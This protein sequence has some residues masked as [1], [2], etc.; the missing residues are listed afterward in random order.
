MKAPKRKY[1]SFE[2][3]AGAGGFTLGLEEAGFHCIGAVEIDAVASQTFERNF[4]Q[5]PCS[6]LG[7][8]NGDVTRVDLR[9]VKRKIRELN[10]DLDLLVAGAPCQGFSRVGRG[11]LDSLNSASGSFAQDPR[12]RL[13]REAIRFLRGLRPRFFLFENVSGIL[14]LRGR[15]AAEDICDAVAR[16]GYVVRLSLVNAAWYGVPQTRER[17]ILIAA[18]KDL[19][20]VPNFPARRHT[21]KLGRG[22]LTGAEL[23]LGNWRRPEYFILPNDLPQAS[24]IEPAVTVREAIGDLPR[25]LEH[26]AAVRSGKRYKSLR[27]SFPSVRY[28][29][30]PDN[31]FSQKMRRWNERLV[32]ESVTDHFCRW[33]PRDFET[34]RQMRPG[35]RY[36]EALLIA[37]RRYRLAVRKWKSAGGSHPQRDAFIPPYSNEG[38][39]EKWRKLNANAPSW[40]ITAHLSK[41]TYS[42][43]HYDS[44]QARA[45]SPREAARLQ[46]FPDAFQ[47]TGNTGDVYRQIGNAVPPLLAYALG[48]AI[49]SSLQGVDSALPLKRPR[50]NIR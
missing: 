22:A 47:F 7:P 20:I 10:V 1:T 19:G 26:L 17:V 42:H 23:D 18:R 48:E 32:C 31:P 4:G 13:Y 28:A 41:D 27:G 44:S 35:D 24:A 49:K 36:P 39:D 38:F 21:A 8:E 6:F 9:Q 14:H 11:K 43:I 34:F 40:T 25:F 37:E 33:T 15:N 45:I 29:K 16:A 5:R 30:R 50:Q 2:L 12:N 46:S 3:F